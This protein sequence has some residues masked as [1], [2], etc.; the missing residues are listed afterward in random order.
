MVQ[1][2]EFL[3]STVFLLLILNRGSGTFS[4]FQNLISI[5]KYE[6]KRYLNIYRHHFYFKS[7]Y[8]QLCRKDACLTIEVFYI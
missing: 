4:V 2:L 5:R 8:L 1:K 3:Y 6:Q 7:E